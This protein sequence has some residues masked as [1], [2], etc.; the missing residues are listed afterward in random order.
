MTSLRSDRSGHSDALQIKRFARIAGAA[1]AIIIILGAV[2]AG[3]LE[4]RLAESNDLAAAVAT[5]EAHETMIRTAFLAEIAMYALVILLALSLYVVLRHVDDAMAKLALLFRGGEAVLGIA[6]AVLATALP[7]QMLQHDVD[8]HLG[9]LALSLAGLHAMGMN[10]ILVLMGLGGTLFFLLFLRSSF[11]AHFWAIWGLAVYLM[12]TVVFAIKIVI[13]IPETVEMTAY[14]F[15]G[16]FELL[17]G[18]RLLIQGVT[19]TT[20]ELDSAPIAAA[21]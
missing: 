5:I 14:A 6:F 10:V 2:F 12:M 16:L 19:I 3:G 1:Y 8:P 20:D 18:L 11:T 9:E 13:P 21:V 17:F 15:G 4:R 7:L